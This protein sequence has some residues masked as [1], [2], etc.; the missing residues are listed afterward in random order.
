MNK[1]FLIAFTIMA[2][3]IMAQQSMTPEILWELGRVSIDDVSDNGDQILYGVT[4][5]NLNENTGKRGLYLYINT[6]KEISTK[7]VKTGEKSASNGVIYP[8]DR[9]GYLQGGQWFVVSSNGLSVEQRTSIEGGIGNVTFSPD[10]SKVFYTAEVKTGKSTLDKYPA[11]NEANVMI[12]DDLMYRHWDHFED[13]MSSHVFWAD[14]NGD[15]GFNAGE[16]IMNGEPFDSPL[17]PFG[18]AEQ[19]SW[20]P[21]SK[22]IAYTSKK[23]K[24]FEYAKST[25]SDIYLFNIETKKITNLTKG[26]MGYDTQPRFSPNGKTV[27]WLSMKRD[28]YEAD[29]NNIYIQDLFTEEWMSLTKDFPETVR[30]FLFDTDSKTIYFLSAT[31]ATYQYFAIELPNKINKKSKAT[32]R[33]ITSGIHNY[34]SLFFASDKLIG[35]RQY[36]NHAN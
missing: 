7:K 1:L 10:F 19:I 32:Y 13:D 24:G 27:A 14:V 2:L 22:T 25:N 23:S 30:S 31:E 12:F 33:S 3:P 35:T 11:Y 18:G 17:Q 9:I 34:T 21:D 20:S 29:K 5:Y 15:G 8:D 16:D 36:M 28:G 6:K 4:Y 26:M